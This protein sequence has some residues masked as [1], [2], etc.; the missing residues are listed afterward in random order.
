VLM[1]SYVGVVFLLP[2][3]WQSSPYFA[4]RMLARALEI[5]K[6]AP[7]DVKSAFAWAEVQL[8]LPGMESYDPG[9]PQ[10]WHIRTDGL[11]TALILSYFD[12][13]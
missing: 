2:F 1:L 12:D 8:N 10:V 6:G 13:G 11:F 4:L 9:L 3:G 5:V 7:D